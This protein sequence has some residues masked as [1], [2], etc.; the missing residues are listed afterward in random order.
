MRPGRLKI[1]VW[2]APDSGY[3]GWFR[4]C[5]SIEGL[6]YTVNTNKTIALSPLQVNMNLRLYIGVMLVVLVIVS[7]RTGHESS[8][9]LDERALLRQ[10]S[11]YPPLLPQE[12]AHLVKL[13]LRARPSHLSSSDLEEISRLVGRVPGLMEY[14][15]SLI[16]DSI[17]FPGMID[18]YAPPTV[19]VMKKEEQHWRVYEVHGFSP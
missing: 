15:V 16:N 4:L 3:N 1:F 10:G 18:V 19:I 7:C 12:K 6:I 13:K 5:P 9:N 17:L 8:V 2:A 14:N 11:E